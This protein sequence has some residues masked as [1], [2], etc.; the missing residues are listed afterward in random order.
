M[1]LL[2]ASQLTT[3]TT[4]NL[5]YRFV[6]HIVFMSTHMYVYTIAMHLENFGVEK[7][8]EYKPFCQFPTANYF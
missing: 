5:A 8:G 7:T 4:G 6:T 1:L 3:M 2:L